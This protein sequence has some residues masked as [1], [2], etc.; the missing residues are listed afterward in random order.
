MLKGVPVIFRNSMQKTVALSVKEAK[1][2][3]AVMTTQDML[4]VL[5]VLESI[6]LYA[7]L[8]MILEVDN[9][10]AVDLSNSWS[11]GGCARHIDV[12]QT[13]LHKLEEEGKLLEKSLPDKDNDTDLFTKNLVGPVFEKFSQVYVGVD[14][15]APDSSS[16]EGVVS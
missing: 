2:Y 16:W 9:K 10:G 11:I 8:T 12:H 15:Y 14:A 6:E 4:Y 5:H 7:P 1:L 13:F 3:A